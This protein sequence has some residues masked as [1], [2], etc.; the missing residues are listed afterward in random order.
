MRHPIIS[1]P[2]VGRWCDDQYSMV[3]SGLS[4]YITTHFTTPGV[5]STRGTLFTTRRVS[6][7]RGQ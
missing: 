1:F 4:V 2:C 6:S 5:V 3:S 7:R